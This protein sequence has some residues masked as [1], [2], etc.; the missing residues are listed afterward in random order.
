MSDGNS[1]PANGAGALSDILVLDLTRVLAGPFCTMVLSDLG[2]RVIKVEP[3][4]GDDARAYG[5]WV[6]GESAYFMSL[7]RGKESVALDLKA[8]GDRALFERLLARADVLVENFRPGALARLG[9]GWEALSERYP[10]TRLRR[11]FGLRT[12][13]AAVAP[14][15]PTT[16]WCRAWAAS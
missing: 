7:N 3:P 2:A 8:D 9:Y 11:V 5:P 10:R 15:P 1:R 13:G 4:G 14:P 16:W 12:D 6:N